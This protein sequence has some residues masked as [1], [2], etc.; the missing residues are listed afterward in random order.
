[1]IKPGEMAKRLGI[2]IKTLYRWEEQGLLVANRTPKNRRYYT[3]AQYN[4]Y[5]ETTTVIDRNSIA[6]ICVPN[7]DDKIIMEYFK[8]L[9]DEAH[10]R[11]DV[12]DMC[13]KDVGSSNDWDRE[14]W[15]NLI[16]YVLNKR[17]RTI[18]IIKRSHFINEHYEWFEKLCHKFNTRIVEIIK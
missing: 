5:V 1:M 12:L 2:S 14:N 16:E 17:V 8:I 15:N 9:E 11:N 3:E 10:Q 13:L 7:N 4:Q 6:Y 18:Y